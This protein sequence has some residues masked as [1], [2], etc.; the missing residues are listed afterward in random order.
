[1]NLARS[2]SDGDF[3]EW[4]NSV[5]SGTP[6]VITNNL[7]N[8]FNDECDSDVEMLEM[9]QKLRDAWWFRVQNNAEDPAQPVD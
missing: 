7:A 9:A 4:V 6:L 5:Q 1:V 8:L 2:P 3:I